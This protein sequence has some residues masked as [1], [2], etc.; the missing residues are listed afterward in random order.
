M[1]AAASTVGAAQSSPSTSSQSP[2]QSAPRIR[3]IDLQRTEVF[4]SAEARFWPFRVANV[5]HAVTRSKV[6]RRELLFA[7]GESYDTARVNESERNLRALGIFRDAEIDSVVTDSGLIVRVRTTDSWTTVPS[8]DVSSSGTQT[9]VN[10]SL[11]ES[12]L[13]GTR[14]VAVVG[15]QSDPDRSSVVVG[16]DSPRVIRN[17]VGVGGSYVDRSDGRAGAASIRYPFFNLSSRRGASIGGQFIDARVLRFEDGDPRP[18]DSLRRKFALVRVDAATALRASSRGFVHVGATAQVRREDFGPEENPEAVPRT[19]SAALGSYVD[20]RA[21]R[22]IRV[23]NVSYIDRVEDVD[24]GFRMRVGLTAAP[25]AWGYD[26]NGVG[27]AVGAGIG[28]RI[29]TGFAFV[30]GAAS[31]L[32]ASGNMDSSGVEASTTLV[33]QP[34][35][36]LLLV[37]FLGGGLLENPRPGAEFDLGL[38]N[39]LRAYPAHS[40]TGD[41]R[42]SMNV[43][44]RLL[45]WQRLFGL[46][47]VG[48]AGFV[49]HAGA[50]FHGSPRRTGTDVGAGLRLASIREAGSVWRLDFAYR[51]PDDVHQPGWVVSIGRGFVLGR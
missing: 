32:Q 31:A 39:A 14:T 10:L 45:L 3:A 43:E 33:M 1:I 42:Y 44:S 28:T 11:Q 35:H 49:D 20:L 46:V 21:P 22:Y 7:P 24:L 4:D 5:L 12:N 15:Y 18:V 6:I 29:P 16:F 23:R 48:V 51:F 36:R 30:Q 13:F 50:W 40:F 27:A 37:G 26:D 19:V 25:R 2:S 17:S 34:H 38:G 9:I 47:G 41:R 8:I